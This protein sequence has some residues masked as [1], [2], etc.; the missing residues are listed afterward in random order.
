M[1]K[2]NSGLPGQSESMIYIVSGY[3]ITGKV[4]IKIE[5]TG[6]LNMFLLLNRESPNN[7]SLKGVWAFQRIKG[8][9]V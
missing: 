4:A 8:L 7:P 6:E 2:V 1:E 3:S 9:T 5:R